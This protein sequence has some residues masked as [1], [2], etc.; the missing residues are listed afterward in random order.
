MLGHLPDHPKPQRRTTAEPRQRSTPAG[1]PPVRPPDAVNTSPLS[2]G[3]ARAHGVRPRRPTPLL[4]GRLGPFGRGA[5]R[6]RSAR[7][8]SPLAQLTRILFPFS[9]SPFS[10]ALYIYI[11]I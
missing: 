6:P 5:A 3:W 7:P 8:K 4:V 11:D 9:F 1:P 2:G 10:F